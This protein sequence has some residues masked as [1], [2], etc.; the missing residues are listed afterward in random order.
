[1]ED[2]EQEL[3]AV[4]DALRNLAGCDRAVAAKSAESL[5]DQVQHT[6]A[7]AAA[8]VAQRRFI[9]R[10]GTMAASLVLL[11]GM[12]S[13]FLMHHAEPRAKEEVTQ[14]TTVDSSYMPAVAVCEDI[15]EQGDAVPVALSTRNRAVTL[16]R[17][18]GVE[19]ESTPPAAQSPAVCSAEEAK[20]KVAQVLARDAQPWLRLRALFLQPGYGETMVFADGVRVDFKGRVVTVSI[21]REGMQQVYQ[22]MGVEDSLPDAVRQLFESYAQ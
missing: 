7:A 13:M 1:M 10:I 18:A 14:E 15:P 6:I 19:P 9:Y 21:E 20:Q 2:N 22:L 12:G 5:H 3:M 17:G 16:T 11:V 8:R 4:E